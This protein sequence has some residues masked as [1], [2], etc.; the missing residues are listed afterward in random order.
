MNS[1]PVWKSIWTHR[2]KMSDWIVNGWKIFP[3]PS[4]RAQY[5]KVINDAKKARLTN[6]ANYTSS[7]PA[8]LLAAMRRMAFEDIPSNPADPK[9]RQGG[10][11]GD[12]YAHWRRG[13][14][15]QQYRLFFRYSEKDRVIVLAWVNDENTKRAYD[16]KTDVYKVF[17][18]MLDSGNPPDDW[19]TLL[20]EAMAA[21][22]VTDD[23]V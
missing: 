22:S 9:F 21:S 20:S 6:P 16:S 17:G 12:G 10:T 23:D 15:L 2:S 7:R 4:F 18:K 5:L 1:S 19:N 3:H 8:K 11:L 14:F 13:K